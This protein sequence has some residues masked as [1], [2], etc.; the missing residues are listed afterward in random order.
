[1]PNNNLELYSKRG[2]FITIEY[3][4][5]QRLFELFRAVYNL[6]YTESTDED[7]IKKRLQELKVAFN[8]ADAF[9][10]GRD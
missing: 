1:M 5:Y 3:R 7:T 6:E 4:E 9:Y 2:H 10:F 8:L